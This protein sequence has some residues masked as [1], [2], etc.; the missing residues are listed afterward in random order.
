MSADAT[1]VGTLAAD[2]FTGIGIPVV[3]LVGDS[4][5]R[6]LDVIPSPLVIEPTANQICDKCATSPASG[7]LVEFGNELVI[8]GNVQSHVPSI[9]HYLH[10]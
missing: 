8:N 2:P 6:C 5:E 7:P 3:A 4:T 9:A 1:L 10:T